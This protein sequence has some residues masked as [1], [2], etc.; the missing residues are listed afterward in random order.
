LVW[1]TDSDARDS[2][3]EFSTHSFPVIQSYFSHSV[4]GDDQQQ[5]PIEKDANVI[6]DRFGVWFARDLSVRLDLAPE[7]LLSYPAKKRGESI[8]GTGLYF[9]SQM[10]I[11]VSIWQD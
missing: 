9:E 5:H 6:V 8:T 7:W 4:S 2:D 3:V 11:C 10:Q 1:V